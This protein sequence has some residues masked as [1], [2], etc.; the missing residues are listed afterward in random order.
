MAGKWMIHPSSSNNSDTQDFEVLVTAEHAWPALE[1]LVLEAQDEV[2]AS[3]RIF[4]FSTPLISTDAKAVGETW[5]DLIADAVRRGVTVRI[6]VSDFDP[7]LAADLHEIAMRTASQADELSESLGDDL[8]GK[9][10]VQVAMHP[11]KVGAVPQLAFFPAVW[12]KLQKLSRKRKEAAVGSDDSPKLPSLYPVSHHQKLAVVDRNVLYIGGLDLNTRRYDTPEHDLP[13]HLTWADVQLVV[14]GPEAEEAATH[15]ENFLLEIDKADC[16]TEFPHISRTLSAPR[17]FG[18]WAVSPK[19]LIKEIEEDHLAAFQRAQQLIYIESQFLRSSVIAD[20]L[21][22]AAERNPHLTLITVLPAM[23]ED[24]A[25]DGNRG[26]DARYGMSLQADALKKITAAFGER[27]CI[28]SP[29]KKVLAAREAPSVLHGSPVIH[30]HSKVLITDQC[31]AL[32]GS[33]NLNGRSM[34]WDTEAAL[35]ITDKGRIS[36][37][38]ETLARHWWQHHLTEAMLD[39]K[40]ALQAWKEEITR[41]RVRRPQARLGYLVPHEADKMEEIHQPV[42]GATENIV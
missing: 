40:L 38:W 32:V 36:T 31:F 6:I 5:S 11:A 19:T 15:L 26:L 22:R 17:R 27:S 14:R 39:Q 13:S 37:L 35:R 41:N 7:I 42:P 1:R 18:F 4:D 20:G 8:A 24:V 23:P 9:L 21:V 25:F 34:R 3:F 33:A 12:R 30:L 28:A 29:V 16:R 2:I 10:R